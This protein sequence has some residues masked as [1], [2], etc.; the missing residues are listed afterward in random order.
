MG[1]SHSRSGPHQKTVTFYLDEC[2]P[3]RVAYILKEVG[4]TITSWH[5]EFQQQQG[6]K[7][8][9][10]I[11][12]IGA[13]G[14]TWIT[15]D[16]EARKE[17]QNDIRVAG[18]SVIWIRGLEREKREPKKNHITIQDLHRMLTDK[19]NDAAIMISTSNKPQYFI[20]YMRANGKPV[21]AKTDLESAFG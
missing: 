5:E 13:K 1:K 10:L 16:Y 8:P 19:L 6:L 3:F 4:Y 12:Y 11:H 15:K 9:Y 14:Y 17:H 18:I 21:L 2:L 7:E 20:L